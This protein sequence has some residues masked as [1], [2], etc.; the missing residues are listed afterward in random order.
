MKKWNWVS[1]IKLS[2]FTKTKTHLQVASKNFAKISIY[3]IISISL[4]SG[5]VYNGATQD[6]F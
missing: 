4:N 5:V 3:L 6:T 1:A 2:H